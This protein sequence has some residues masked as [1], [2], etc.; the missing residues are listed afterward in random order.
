MNESAV[1]EIET[2]YIQLTILLHVIDQV[3]EHFLQLN[4]RFQSTLVIAEHNEKNLTP[5]TQNAVTA[6]TKIGSDVTVLVAGTDCAAVSLVFH[7]N[8]I[9]I[10]L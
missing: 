5:I 8:S 10:D 2:L 9:D 4:R 1:I 7:T 3:C 6:A